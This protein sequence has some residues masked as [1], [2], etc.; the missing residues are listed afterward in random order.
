MKKKKKTN[1]RT[2]LSLTPFVKSIAVSRWAW[3][4]HTMMESIISETNEV[5]RE[6][7]RQVQTDNKYVKQRSQHP[8]PSAIENATENYAQIPP[9]CS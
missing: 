8:Q 1:I 7:S 2:S 9:Y 3:T 5:N 4:P 6:F